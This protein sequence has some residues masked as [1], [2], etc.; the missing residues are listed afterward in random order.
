MP[1]PEIHHSYS[2]RSNGTAGD[3]PYNAKRR[4]GSRD[5][6]VID[7]D[8]AMGE[9]ACTARLD[10]LAFHRKPLADPGCVDETNCKG[11]C[12]QPRRPAHDL[13]AA[14]AHRRRSQL[15]QFRTSSWRTE[16]GAHR[17]GVARSATFLEA[18]SR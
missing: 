5:D 6:N 4:I 2:I 14:I 16:G 15:C 7:L 12:R 18:S 17:N 13:R 1:I 3:L 9:A 8:Q 10:D 11:D